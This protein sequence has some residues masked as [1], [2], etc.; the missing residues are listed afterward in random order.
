MSFSDCIWE[1]EGECFFF[2][3][4]YVGV[5]QGLV[6]FPIGYRYVLVSLLS[7]FQSLSKISSLV[8]SIRRYFPSEL[9]WF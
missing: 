3:P 4:S 9:G 5:L 6:V 2:S 8:F 7:R 1:V